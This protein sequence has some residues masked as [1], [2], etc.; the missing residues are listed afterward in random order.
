MNVR[1]V[2]PFTNEEHFVHPC[3]KCH[4]LST[5]TITSYNMLFEEC[6]DC[7]GFILSST[8]RNITVLLNGRI[9]KE[10]KKAYKL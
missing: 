2:G 5:H 10:Y 4:S 9:N 7:D 8:Y 6:D 1:Y 3:S